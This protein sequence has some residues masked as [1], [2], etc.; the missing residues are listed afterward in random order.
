MKRNNNTDKT[1]NRRRFLARSGLAAAGA[2]AIFG[3]APERSDAAQP[4]NTG[5]YNVR[6]HGASGDG[7]TLDTKAIQQ[8]ID[9]CA[10]AGGGT[11]YFPAGTF[12]SGTL[13]LK[14]DVNLHFDSGSMLLGSTNLDDYP[15]TVQDLRS[16][17]DN[18]T[19][20]SLIFAEKVQNI[21]IT[22][23]GTLD[24]QGAVFSGPY[25]VRPYMI[26]VIESENITVKDVTIQNSPMWVQHYLGCENVNIDGIT[27]HSKMNRN[28]DGIDIDSCEKVRIANCEIWSGDDAIVLKATTYRKCRDVTVTNCVL[29]TD[30]NAFKLGTESSGGF[31]NIVLDN[32]TMYDVGLSGIALE[33]VDG[34]VFDRVSI[35]NVNMVNV[36][37]AIFIRLGN[38]A[39]PPEA[40]R[41]SE[42]FTIP[43]GVE[44][45]GVGSLRNVMISNIQ[46]TV[47]DGVGCSITGL[48]GHLAENI[49]L[50]NIRI[51]FPG[52][53]T[54]EEARRDIPEVPEHYPE[55]TMFGTL[56]AYGFFC[57]HA[58]NV[59][60]HHV[61]V[62]LRDA[63]ARPAYVFDDVSDLELT[64]IDG[65]LSES[66]PA[67]IRLYNTTDVFVH[68]SRPAHS[69]HKFAQFEGSETGS[70]TMLNN[71]F[72]KVEEVY[73]MEDGVSKTALFEAG[74]RT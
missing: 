2:G 56:S 55:Y 53:G 17:T 18:Y 66:A 4:L 47:R 9:A 19:D 51:S 69:L 28:N 61:Q 43:E 39:R 6:D 65:M 5:L 21:S 54:R 59:K 26:R 48:A 42:G 60:F 41:T 31:E 35:S 70:I 64:G 23:R 11:V 34:A 74:N 22:G 72:S 33:E 38:R 40:K 24:G 71:D 50:E 57:R 32:C 7:E 25:K 16:Y 10:E 63:D 45:P 46:A 58:R 29:S 27:V 20:K 14:S 3:I 67:L 37:N 15:V 30:C 44:K 12:L 1:M 8:A 62:D 73:S 36:D 49:T 52:G 68:G 13:Y